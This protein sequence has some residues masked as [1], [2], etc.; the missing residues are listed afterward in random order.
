[1]EKYSDLIYTLFLGR[2]FPISLMDWGFWVELNILVVL[3]R[4]FGTLL[5][6]FHR[7]VQLNAPAPTEKLNEY[8]HLSQSPASTFQVN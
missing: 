5:S 8:E 2:N 4:D 6:K 3:S 1:V 7:D